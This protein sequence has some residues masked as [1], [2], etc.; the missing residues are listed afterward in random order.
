MND[1]HQALS[2]TVTSTSQCPFALRPVT[3]IIAKV[4][5]HKKGEDVVSGSGPQ[6]SDWNGFLLGWCVMGLHLT[7]EVVGLS[8][9]RLRSKIR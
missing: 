8:E 1:P 6:P 2:K 7:S 5:A 9:I 4:A 3:L